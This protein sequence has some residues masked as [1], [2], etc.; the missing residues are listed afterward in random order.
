MY[1]VWLAH[2]GVWINN[3]AQWTLLY[4]I[5]L[6]MLTSVIRKHCWMSFTQSQVI[7][8][9]IH[10]YLPCRSDTRGLTTFSTHRQNCQFNTLI[11]ISTNYVIALTNR[12]FSK[13]QIYNLCN[14]L[15]DGLWRCCALPLGFTWS[16]IAP[17]QQ[18]IWAGN[19]LWKKR[20]FQRSH[21]WNHDGTLCVCVCVRVRLTGKRKRNKKL[22]SLLENSL[23]EPTRFFS[24]LE[25]NVKFGLYRCYFAG[26]G[27]VKRR[28]RHTVSVYIH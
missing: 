6:T 18:N 16:E 22:T 27:N 24:Y 20:N 11:R 19:G 14:V 1:T 15:R 3:S 5:T 9:Q 10:S 25:K 2:P 13:C 8:G 28:E 26:G 17:P 4:R 12:H 21:H 23:M 7:F